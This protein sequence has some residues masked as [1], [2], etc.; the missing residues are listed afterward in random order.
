MIAWRRGRP[1]LARKSFCFVWRKKQIEGHYHEVAKSDSTNLVAW[2]RDTLA[3]LSM[4]TIP[5]PR[6]MQ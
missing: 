5:S 1:S 3:F 2:S 4:L 6:V